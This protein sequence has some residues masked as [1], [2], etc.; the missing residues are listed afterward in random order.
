MIGGET[1]ELP[2]MY[3]E[4][5]FDLAGFSV[6]V[7]EKSKIIDPSKINPGDSVIGLLSSGF[8]S[9]GYSLVRKVVQ[10]KNL[11]LSKDYGFGI[12]GDVLMT[13]TEIYS[14]ILVKAVEK[15]G[16]KKIK[17]ISH[18]T[19]GG[20]EGN[21]CRVLPDNLDALVVKG[22]WKVPGEMEFILKEGQVSR[23]EG[24]KVF[25][26]GIG[27][28]IIIDKNSKKD[29]LD[30]FNCCSFRAVEIGEVIEGYGEVKFK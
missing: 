8:H 25:N 2:G 27:M 13:P 20:I 7:V 11:D 22:S 29:V 23:D 5:E 21:L 4:D 6:G 1:A 3:K 14:P 24:F 10:D 28:A 26:M 19:G 9:N 17:G 30:Y 18:I 16:S 12:L 15:F